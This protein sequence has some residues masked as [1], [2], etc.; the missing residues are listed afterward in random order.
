M[1]PKSKSSESSTL[2]KD[3]H[4]LAWYR[5]YR[6]QNFDEV[7]GQDHIISILKQ[8]ILG[9][10]IAHAYLFSG[11]RGTGKT[12]V[13]R[14]FAKEIGVTNSDMYE[15]D[16][17]SNTSIED[18]RSLNES[19][20]ALPIESPYKVYILDEVH[21]L[22]KSAFNALLKTLEEPPKHV[23]F[24]LATT[25]IHKLPETVISRCESY[26]FKTP[27]PEVLRK[28]LTNVSKAEKVNIDEDALDLVALLG[29]GSF[30]DTLS[31]F[32]KV[33]TIGH[34]NTTKI[35]SE[36]IAK[37]T[38]AP[39]SE[40]ISTL[41][42]AWSTKDASKLFETMSQVEESGIDIKVL[43]KMLTDRA[44]FLLMKKVSP[45]YATVFGKRF[46]EKESTMLESLSYDEKG[47]ARLL[48]VLV[49]LL[50]EGQSFTIPAVSLELALISSIGQNV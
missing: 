32:Q 43:V 30:R 11:T 18:I 21:M 4:F 40:L 6:P 44:R 28:V 9:H 8:S 41:L 47:A 50:I 29:D 27:T 13:A 12:S 36:H 16:A 17:A 14:I 3:T 7:V 31:M 22:S 24:I 45:A 19:V 23:I 49:S 39:R 42:A 37:L 38:G 46:G 2:G 26:V 35:T 34:G 33:A 10:K 5:K 15:I 20:H 25:E 48:Q 1:S